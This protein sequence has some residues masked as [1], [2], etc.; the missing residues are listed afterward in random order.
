MQ[1]LLD[2]QDSE[3]SVGATARAHFAIHRGDS[4]SSQVRA[5]HASPPD[6]TRL[7]QIGRLLSVAKCHHSL[8][9]ER[10]S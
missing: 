7:S 1:S 2:A 9:G 8:P 3:S 6:G 10:D 5:Q 4:E